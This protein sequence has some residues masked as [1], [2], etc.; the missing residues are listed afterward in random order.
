MFGFFVSVILFSWA[1]AE[2]VPHSTAIMRGTLVFSTSRRERLIG[3][4]TLRIVSTSLIRRCLWLG[5][6]DGLDS[7]ALVHRAV[8]FGNLIQREAEVKD[9]AGVDLIRPDQIDQ[10]R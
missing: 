9:L 5:L 2:P 1:T 3:L 6:K 4:S 8:T 10:L 7:A